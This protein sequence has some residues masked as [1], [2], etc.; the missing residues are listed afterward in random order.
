[1]CYI[2]WMMIVLRE[3]IIAI[4]WIDYSRQAT[5]ITLALHCDN[6]P[7]THTL[8]LTSYSYFHT[9]DFEFVLCSHIV[10]A[11][12][13]YR[14]TLIY[15]CWRPPHTHILASTYNFIYYLLA[16]KLWCFAG[17][18]LK[19]AK[20][21]LFSTFSLFPRIACAHLRLC[22]R[23]A[24]GGVRCIFVAKAIDRNGSNKNDRTTKTK[25]PPLPPPTTPY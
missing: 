1:M 25:V 23:W 10:H 19:E 4:G 13:K 21:S 3:C 5:R 17:A 6:A 7:N 12:D 24:F 8:P 9:R 15:W 14:T 11:Y 22:M 16:H 18:P 2:I 20:R